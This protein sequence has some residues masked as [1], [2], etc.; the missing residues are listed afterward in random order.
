MA[1]PIIPVATLVARLNAARSKASKLSKELATE[2]MSPRTRK[3][4]E[5]ELR[6][7]VSKA[8]EIEKQIPP[9]TPGFRL[10]GEV[11]PRKANMT[12][13]TN[14]FSKYNTSGPL[15]VAGVPRG[16]MQMQRG[17][18]VDLDGGREEA[19]RNFDRA[20]F[21]RSLGP[22]AFDD[23]PAAVRAQVLDDLNRA[24]QI[25]ELETPPP[26][27]G[28]IMGLGAAEANISDGRADELGLFE[29]PATTPDLPPIETTA[30]PPA[31]GLNVPASEVLT[32][33]I[34]AGG[35]TPDEMEIVDTG[36]PFTGEAKIT[37]PPPKRAPIPPVENEFPDLPPPIYEA[38]PPQTG[39][40][41]TGDLFPQLGP[42]DIP[43]RGEAAPVTDADPNFNIFGDDGFTAQT[44]IGYT[45]P[46]TPIRRTGDPFADAVEGEYQMPIYKPTP[47]R[48]MPFLSIDYKTPRPAGTP[49]PPP[50]SEDYS[51]GSFGR[52]MFNEAV[53][54]W[55][56]RYGAVEDYVPPSEEDE[57]NGGG[58]GGGGGGGPG[59]GEG[60]DRGEYPYDTDPSKDS[61][62]PES[63]QEFFYRY[64]EPPPERTSGGIG[65]TQRYNRLLAEW[66]AKYG[67]VEDYNEAKARAMNA[68]IGSIGM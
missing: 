44:D 21:L 56:S 51:T 61:G 65:P 62:R 34:V 53:Q 60:Q 47:T 1:N 22:G 68:D 17:G 19:Y 42:P 50:K 9:G 43:E 27:T 63:L 66:E 41:P 14:L 48:T 49:P 15:L 10:G 54:R 24:G 35:P 6:T 13:L 23:V 36:D 37:L 30:P 55:E 45:G 20:D 31:T 5:N 46:E 7:T 57:E 26:V 32:S 12:G 18:S 4:I 33:G 28:P 25:A 59:S 64:P 29:N 38:P 3:K 58:G 67:P 40:P 52:L 2:S 11:M 16:T 8:R 39:P